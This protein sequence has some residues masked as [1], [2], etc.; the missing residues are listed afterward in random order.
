M[1]QQRQF[2][3]S[4]LLGE[5]QE[6]HLILDNISTIYGTS[7]WAIEAELLLRGTQGNCAPEELGDIMKQASGNK[8]A[9][10]VTSAIAIRAQRETS[11]SAFYRM[12]VETPGKAG[13]PSPEAFAASSA[14]W[15]RVAPSLL[16]TSSKDEL[17]EYLNYESS[18]PI[19]DI[20]QTLR[21][22]VEQL[23]LHDRAS[24][25]HPQFAST[26]KK[27]AE[28]F[29]VPWL[30]NIRIS[31]SWSPPPKSL[32]NIDSKLS[33]ACSNYAHH[34]FAE[35]FALCKEAALSDPRNG[36]AIHLAARAALHTYDDLDQIDFGPPGSLL[37]EAF[38]DTFEFFARKPDDISA[39][40]LFLDWSLTYCN[41]DFGKSMDPEQWVVSPAYRIARYQTDH[42]GDLECASLCEMLLSLP[43]REPPPPPLS[44]ERAAGS[45]SL[46]YA[47]QLSAQG[48]ADAAISEFQ[49][50]I[51]EAPCIVDRADAFAQMIELLAHTND[52]KNCAV[53]I[54]RAYATNPA[55]L[56]GCDLRP[57]AA[58]AHRVRFHGPPDGLE[59]IAE[60]P[61]AVNIANQVS[62]TEEPYTT[63]V[64]YDEFLES[65]DCSRPSE[66]ANRLSAAKRLDHAVILFLRDVC[67]K[68]IMDSSYVFE[69]LS[70]IE[71]ERISICRFLAAH[72]DSDLANKMDAEISEI[73]RERLVRQTI[74][75]AGSSK[76][77]VNTEGVRA[78]LPEALE[79][80]LSHI[81][82]YSKLVLASDPIDSAILHD[83]LRHFVSFFL[84]RLFDQLVWSEQHGLDSNLSIRIRH[85]TLE[86]QLRG[87]FE[88]FSLI[89]MRGNST[90][91]DS[92]QYAENIYWRERIASFLSPEDVQMVMEALQ[93]LSSDVDSVITEL[94][95]EWFHINRK[96]K[97]LGKFAASVLPD[98]TQQ[99]FDF[100]LSNP[101]AI[102]Q[103]TVYD[104]GVRIFWS[105]VGR[106]CTRI[107]DSL[108]HEIH[109]RLEDVLEELRSAID[110]FPTPIVRD[111]LASIENCR[112]GLRPE[113]E[114]IASWLEVP[115]QNSRQGIV[116]LDVVV[117]ACINSMRRAERLDPTLVLNAEN[118]MISGHHSSNLYHAI[119][120][121]VDN[122]IQHGDG[123]LLEVHTENRAPGWSAVRVRNGVSEERANSL[124]K[125]INVLADR[126]KLQGATDL[127][128]RE[129]GSGFYKLGRILRHDLGLG[130]SYSVDV[131]LEAP[132]VV[133]VEI[134]LHNAI[135]GHTHDN[136]NN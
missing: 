97:P 115:I 86:G 103:E 108:R 5:L 12:M 80:A 69:S 90:K 81:T 30:E 76:I 23:A 70:Q 111:M 43:T 78:Q 100:L 59:S 120:I 98:E 122:A 10:L 28:A 6:A 136:T 46:I 64:A 8:Y 72:G 124:S 66:L 135:L 4:L 56:V 3:K 2:E 129:G 11:A 132:R 106:S 117:Q 65:Q 82:L 85:G 67:T 74:R 89:T 19:I 24:E 48:K 41:L 77:H 118:I 33:D 7:L 73:I 29:D 58:L 21:A 83:L 101:T 131:T 40:P 68:D 91:E 63:Y 42:N 126:A 107:A 127:I 88:K 15:F 93:Q 20:F 123:S 128:R 84:G 119:S 94:R 34:K 54:S 35:S 71:D 121:I 13:P 50:T 45:A 125:S 18:L 75:E 47:R 109:R 32:D 133:S 116:S 44:P 52:W 130:D 105:K 39:T 25:I 17:A 49:R 53:A 114:T 113:L 1:S 95:D 36:F 104:E 14:W 99:L 60:W 16:G 9:T 87:F 22:T 55:F 38:R 51:N 57:I 110:S 134:S 31:R 79:Q 96:V 102:S 27:L 37:H 92:A 112:A 26:A 62:E 61:V